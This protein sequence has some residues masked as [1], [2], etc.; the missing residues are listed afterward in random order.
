MNL[1]TVVCGSTNCGN[2]SNGTITDNRV[3]GYFPIIS[4]WLFWVPETA[5]GGGTSG[6]GGSGNATDILA[7]SGGA[8]VFRLSATNAGASNNTFTCVFNVPFSKLTAG[9]G[10]VI[11]DIT[12]LV[13]TQT[14]Q[15]TSITL[16]TLKSFTPPAPIDPETANSAT[17]VTAGGTITQA[18]TST[19]FAAYSPV[20]AGQF[21]SVK[22]SLGTP[23]A[24]NTDLQTFQFVIVFAQSASAASL[25]EVPGFYVHGS[26]ILN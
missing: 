8:R 4:D 10:V 2:T 18:P 12:F 22:A 25:Q 15:P 13:S 3:A 23:A 1:A 11:N 14:T 21:F 20:S 16:P 6:T 7:T 26:T 19:Q 17:F 24:V 9:H 5:C